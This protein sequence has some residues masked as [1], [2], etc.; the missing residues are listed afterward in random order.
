MNS[1]MIL[2]ANDRSLEARVMNLA[3]AV[4]RP[5]A[6]L[7]DYYSQV[8]G[9]KVGIK[10][11]LLLLNAQLAFL[12]TAFSGCSLVVRALCVVWLLSALARCKA[13]LA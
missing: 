11:T 13:A 6:A 12:F 8:A 1:N 5:V 9:K 3:K 7:A 4:R 10:Q 2:T